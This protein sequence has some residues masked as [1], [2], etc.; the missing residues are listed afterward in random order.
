MGVRGRFVVPLALAAVCA[1]QWA[2]SFAHASDETLDDVISVPID[3]ILRAPAGSL[4]L[5]VSSPVPSAFQGSACTAVVS[6]QNQQSMHEGNHLVLTSGDATHIIENVESAAF[7][8]TGASVPL[9]LGETVDVSVRM[10]ADGVS[11]FG[12][13]ITIRCPLNP[14]EPP[15]S[16]PTTTTTEVVALPPVQQRPL[17]TAS[18]GSPPTRRCRRPDRGARYG[19]PPLAGSC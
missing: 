16:P 4:N 8:E 1:L 13:G 17:P 5:I 12:F 11:S 2:P 14:A 15:T 9:I 7:A 10:G 3:H 18:P 19:Q 6:A